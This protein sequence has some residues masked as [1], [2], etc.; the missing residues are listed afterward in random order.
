M[1][2]KLALLGNSIVAILLQTVE[3]V[4][5]E[6]FGVGNAAPDDLHEV[7]VLG[8]AVGHHK[9]ELGVLRR[10]TPSVL[11]PLEGEVPLF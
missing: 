3:G 4:P 7:I 10:R 5:H 11:Y 8:H 2:R 9:P 6:L 1:M